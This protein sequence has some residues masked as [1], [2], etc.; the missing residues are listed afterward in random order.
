MGKRELVLIALFL[1]A[2]V[3]V[4]QVTAPPAPPGSD[5]SVGGIFE[6]A[7]RQMRGAR[8][9][10][11]G[12]SRQTVAVSAAATIVRI[13]LPRPCDVTI[14]GADRDDIAIVVH[15]TAR[16]YTQAEAKA[17][18]DAASVKAGVAGEAVSLTGVWEDRRSPS[19]YIVQSAIS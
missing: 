13:S 19:G 1:V 10:A 11:S 9:S 17:A 8:E 12:E 7:K 6:R 4:Y 15:T 2:G 5:L 14:I 16:G 3:V 18:A